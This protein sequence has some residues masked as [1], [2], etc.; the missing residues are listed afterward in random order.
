MC[1]GKGGMG[2]RHVAGQEACEWLDRWVDGWAGGWS[3]S[4][5][6][7]PLNA[8]GYDFVRSFLGSGFSAPPSIQA[9][10]DR[11]HTSSGL[12]LS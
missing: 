4:W 3:D 11:S 2:S 5:D 7:D 8:H 9:S 10:D 6:H 1:A 12:V